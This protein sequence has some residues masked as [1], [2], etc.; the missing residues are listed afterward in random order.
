MYICQSL[1][2]NRKTMYTLCLRSGEVHAFWWQRYSSVHTPETA[3]VYMHSLRDEDIPDICFSVEWKLLR[4]R[5]KTILPSKR[6]HV[7]YS[8]FRLHHRVYV[9][10]TY[11][12]RTPRQTPTDAPP[13]LSKHAPGVTLPVY[14]HP[15]T[16][17]D[18][19]TTEDANKRDQRKRQ[20][21]FPY[22]CLWK[23]RR[24]IIA[25]QQLHH[26]IYGNLLNVLP[27]WNLQ[28]H[29]DGTLLSDTQGLH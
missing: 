9:H 18:V 12:P 14:I 21:L 28:R 13:P 6:Q 26:E 27:L 10:P 7:G 1:F 15:S 22:K 29:N 25:C 16:H 4:R 24:K 20:F 2:V 5:R 17:V 8:R 3:S 11:A 23:E 19:Y